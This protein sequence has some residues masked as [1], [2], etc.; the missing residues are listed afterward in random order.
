MRCSPQGLGGGVDTGTANLA[1]DTV[2]P[3]TVNILES[4][5]SLSRRGRWRGLEV[6]QESPKISR[7]LN[8]L[9]FGKP[10]N[11][12]SRRKHSEVCI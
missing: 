5:L 3:K 6:R 1:K 7:M 10:V 4:L 8:E 11:R 2:P 12:L 9:E